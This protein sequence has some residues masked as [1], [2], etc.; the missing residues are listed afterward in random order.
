[1]RLIPSESGDEYE[2]DEDDTFP[3]NSGA[4]VEWTELMSASLRAEGFREKAQ[5]YALNAWLLQQ[6]ASLYEAES[7]Q[8]SAQ[9][10]AETGDLVSKF[11]ARHARKAAEDAI[12]VIREAICEEEVQD[13]QAPWYRDIQASWYKQWVTELNELTPLHFIQ[14]VSVLTVADQ[15]EALFQFL[16]SLT[17]ELN[18]W[19]TEDRLRD[20]PD[21]RKALEQDELSLSEWHPVIGGKCFR[22]L[23]HQPLSTPLSQ[24]DLDICLDHISTSKFTSTSRSAGRICS[25]FGKLVWQKALCSDKA[26]SRAAFSISPCIKLFDESNATVALMLKVLLDAGQESKCFNTVIGR[27]ILEETARRTSRGHLLDTTVDFLYILVLVKMAWYMDPKETSQTP[28]TW[29]LVLFAVLS[30]II[31]TSLILKLFGGMYLFSDC[32]NC[33]GF[34]VGVL[35]HVNLWNV[36][37]SLT[38]AFSTFVG[39][40]FVLYACSDGNNSI[41]SDGKNMSH[42]SHAWKLFT[43][44]PA[45]LSCLVLVRWTQVGV[46][47]LQVE[48]IGRNIVPVFY[49][50]TRPASINFLVFLAIVVCG[51]FHAYSVFPISENFGNFSHQFNAFLKIFRLEVLGDFDLSELEGLG[52]EINGTITK[53]G[54][55]EAEV[56]EETHSSIHH[57]LR[58]EFLVLTLL[59]TVVAM[60]VYIGLL[61][62]LYSKAVQKKNRLYNHYLASTSYRFISRSI[63]IR[64]C[65]CGLCRHVAEKRSEGLLWFSYEKEDLVDPRA[66][67]D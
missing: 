61:G 24:N 65:L 31:A 63:G 33:N 34:A 3:V 21:V 64:V 47:L 40:R 5:H 15:Q 39:W 42:E 32:V 7:L 14:Y 56:E 12:K 67:E 46:S 41:N 4:E 16:S 53:K 60:N 43:D 36:I 58:L 44:H 25:D 66:D 49:A 13:I 38:E 59:V 52:E 8:L 11:K 23:F 35:K 48:G 29:V 50:V 20:I 51:S 9:K 57:W 2:D 30:L 54:Q 55:V 28:P 6:K 17:M 19:Q 22:I 10:V 1:M 45:F 62:E 18:W 37:F 26:C 27:A